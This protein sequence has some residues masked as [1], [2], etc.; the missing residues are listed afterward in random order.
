[1]EGGMTW[2]EGGEYERVNG[3]GWVGSKETWVERFSWMEGRDSWMDGLRYV[4]RHRWM[5]T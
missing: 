1:M 4:K 2:L 3:E 5:V